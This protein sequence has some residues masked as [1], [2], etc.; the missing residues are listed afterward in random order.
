MEIHPPTGLWSAGLVITAASLFVRWWFPVIPRLLASAGVGLCAGFS[1]WTLFGDGLMQFVLFLSLGAAVCALAES[2]I[3]RHGADTSPNPTVPMVDVL[4][5]LARNSRWA[6][7]LPADIKRNGHWVNWQLREFVEQLALGRV[8]AWGRQTKPVRHRTLDKID[9]GFWKHIKGLDINSI[10]QD[11]SDAH[12][13]VFEEQYA[14]GS[15]SY[16]GQNSPLRATFSDVR[17]V[18]GNVLKIW[19]RR[20]ILDRLFRRSAPEVIKLDKEWQSRDQKL[21][22]KAK[23]LGVFR[24]PN[25]L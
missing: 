17:F 2:I 7:S 25:Q 10:M 4:R 5:Y 6:A 14:I 11:N 12:Q 1:A 24:R 15:I 23:S 22:V 21:D 3:G 18:R 9:Q 8:Q 16:L 20:S 13:V 19:P